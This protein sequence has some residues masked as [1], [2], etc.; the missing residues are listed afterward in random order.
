M[1]LTKRERGEML[2]MLSD[3]GAQAIL[4]EAG[5]ISSKEKIFAKIDI[6]TDKVKMAQGVESE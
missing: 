2:I 3:I 4:L 5:A 6:L 1:V